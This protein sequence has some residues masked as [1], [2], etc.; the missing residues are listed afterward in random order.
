MRQVCDRFKTPIREEKW[1]RDR[2][3]RECGRRE[4]CKWMAVMV[5]GGKNDS[6][7]GCR[8][9]WDGWELL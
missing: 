5:R 3:R 7:D 4:G 2:K 9:R 6:I 1:R 8:G